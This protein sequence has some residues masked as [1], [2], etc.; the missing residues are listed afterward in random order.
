MKVGDLVKYVDHQEYPIDEPYALTNGIVT[1]F[2]YQG[3]PVVFFFGRNEKHAYLT[4]D[5]EVLN[6]SR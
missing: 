1:G 3:D 6:E 5:I 2:D 4:E